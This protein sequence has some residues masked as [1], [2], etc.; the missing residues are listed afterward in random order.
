M[1]RGR[2]DL[3]ELDSE[4]R[5]SQNNNQLVDSNVSHFFSLS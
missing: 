5:A 2:R 4:R 3:K 1:K